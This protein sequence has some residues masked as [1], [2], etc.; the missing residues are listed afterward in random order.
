MVFVFIMKE[1]SAYKFDRKMG[2]RGLL[3]LFT[4]LYIHTFSLIQHWKF[5]F[6]NKK[7]RIFDSEILQKTKREVFLI[8]AN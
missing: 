1:K 5:A 7:N 6:R 4:K 3:I 2:R 8:L